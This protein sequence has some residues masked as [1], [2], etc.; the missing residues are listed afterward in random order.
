MESNATHLADVKK[1]NGRRRTAEKLYTD[2]RE[3]Y[4]K[5]DLLAAVSEYVGRDGVGCDVMLSARPVLSLGLT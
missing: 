1:S 3:I 2:L 5:S 4:R